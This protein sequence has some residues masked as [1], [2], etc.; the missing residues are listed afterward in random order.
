MT[1]AEL[2]MV[3]THAAHTRV[4]AASE[5]GLKKRSGNYFSTSF[6]AYQ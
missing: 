2:E 5:K 3:P 1:A 6:P 4:S